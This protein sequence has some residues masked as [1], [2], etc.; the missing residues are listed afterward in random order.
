VAVHLPGILRGDGPGGSCALGE[1]IE[2]YGEEIYLDLK[3]F[4]GFDLVGFIAGEVFSS[5]RV[6]SSMIRNLP[7]GSRFLAAIAVDRPEL[8]EDN[9]ETDP[10]TE[11][12]NDRR[13]WTLDRRLAAMAV[14]AVNTHTSVSVQWKGKP[15]EFPTIGPADWQSP[16]D[17]SRAQAK[18]EPV[19]TDNFDFFR[20]IGAPVG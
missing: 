9:P 12:I 13:A 3:E 8:S 11:A 20:K 10:R 18:P 14:N 19:Y 2:E 4:W 15:P 17:R 1:L 6:I 16:T 5:I 7:E